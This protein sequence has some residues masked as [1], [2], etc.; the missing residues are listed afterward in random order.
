VLAVA[1]LIRSAPPVLLVAGAGAGD[2]LA[3]LAAERLAAA[4]DVV[5]LAWLLL[6]AAAVAGS[7]SVEMTAVRRWPATRVGPFVLLCQTVVPVL[8]APVVAGEDWSADAGLVAGGLALVA[9]GGWWLA[10][11]GGL[12]ENGEA[13]DDDVGRPRQR[14][15]GRVRRARGRQGD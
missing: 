14:G 3:A 4:W 8:L 10:R 13:L 6:A 1:F 12:L 9:A 15:P 2:A 7:L 11:S 5:A